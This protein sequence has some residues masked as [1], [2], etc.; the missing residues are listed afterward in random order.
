[1]LVEILLEERNTVAFRDLVDGIPKADTSLI[2]RTGVAVS[3]NIVRTG[4]AEAPV[5]SRRSQQPITPRNV[6]FCSPLPSRR[7][8]K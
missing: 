3:T 6:T 4:S 1:M 2:T 8:P 5:N 7:L